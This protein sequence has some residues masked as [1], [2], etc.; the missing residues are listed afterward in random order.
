MKLLPLLIKIFATPP[1][2]KQT[3]KQTGGTV[4]KNP[5]AI[6]GDAGDTGSISGSRRPPGGEHDNPLQYTCLKNTILGI[7]LL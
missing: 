4:V 3:N 1:L 5:P 2:P 6:A 7:S